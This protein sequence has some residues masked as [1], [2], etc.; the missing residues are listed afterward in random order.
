MRRLL[1][2]GAA[3]LVAFALA[4]APGSPAFAVDCGAAHCYSVAQIRNTIYG[5]N[6]GLN[7]HCLGP[8]NAPTGSNF[9]TQEQWIGT[10][11]TSGTYWVEVGMAY[12]YPQGSTRYFFWGDGRPNG[13][14]VHEHDLTIAANLN[15][16]YD[17]YINWIGNNSWRVSRDGTTLGTSTAN[18][19]SS[20]GGDAGEEMTDTAGSSSA[21]TAWLFRQTSSGG[22]W[23]SSWPG[24][25]LRAD[26]PPYGTWSTKDY[27]ASFYSNCSFLSAAPDPGPTFVPFTAAEAPSVIKDI[28]LQMAA[29]NGET[30]PTSLEYVAT[31]RQAA[32]QLTAQAGVD[33]DQP[34]YLVSVHGA[35]VGH[36]AKRP[37]GTAEPQG[38]VLTVTID[39]KTGR[40]TDWGIEQ[41]TPKLTS[42]GAVQ[43]LG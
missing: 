43:Q 35:F 39:P 8:M 33:S 32:A 12:G 18:P 5:V 41:T 15:T 13:G 16:T 14:G 4:A 37:A 19:G 29:T 38:T 1:A 24:A 22:P 3:V 23:Y 42:L 28:A 21:V 20:R 27:S 2:A 6:Q 31:T 9:M 30:A 36:M 7:V 11:N 25:G 10:N 17:D 26:E 34:V 40:I